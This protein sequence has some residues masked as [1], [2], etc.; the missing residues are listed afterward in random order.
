MFKGWCAML[1]VLGDS[2]I[3]IQMANIFSLPGKQLAY[4]HVN[5]STHWCSTTLLLPHL[6]QR[7]NVKCE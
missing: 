6:S 1:I 3:P 4:P 7:R 2:G 5:H